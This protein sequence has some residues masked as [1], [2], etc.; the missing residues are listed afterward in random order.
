MAGYVL[1]IVIEDT[2]PPVWRRV[3]IPEMV[4]FAELH[5]VI[6]I[7]FGWSGSHLHIF[8]I[9]SEYTCIADGDV[10]G[11]FD[12]YIEKETLVEQFFPKNK[13]IRY[14]YDFGDEWRHKIIYEK[15][16]ENY[17][18]RYTTLLK[19]RGDNFPED[20]GGVWGAEADG[21]TRS[22]FDQEEVSG[23]LRTL[24]CPFHEE[25]AV[26]LTEEITQEYIEKM[27][28]DFVRWLHSN[29]RT[30]S[31]ESDRKEAPSRLS[32]RINLWKEFLENESQMQKSEADS[33]NGYR[34]MTLPFIREEDLQT[35]GATLEI[36]RGEKTM[37]EL[38]C[39][40]GMKEARD[41]CKYLQISI[42]DSWPVSRMAEM[43]AQTFREHP[44]YILYI[45]YE[46]QYKEFLR[47][48]KFPC[49]IVRERPQDGDVLIKAISIGLA[50]LKVQKRKNGSRASLSFAKDLSDILKSLNAD[51]KKQT[52]RKLKK[53]AKKLE[54]LI[55]VYGLID[56][57]SLYEMFRQ[58]Y[59]ETMSREELYRG[60]Y[61]YA[62]MNELVNTGYY[63]DGG[64]Y[65]SALQIDMEYILKKKDEYAEGLNYV[66][67]PAAEIEK[68]A[69]DI[70][71]RSDWID[72]LFT[73]LHF[74]LGFTEDMAAVLLEEIFSSVVNG[75]SITE[76][77]GIVYPLL[78]KNTNLAERCE[79]WEAVVSLM[80]EVE[81]PMLKGRSR[82]MY[83]EEMGE[84]PWKTG[85]LKETGKW[86]NSKEWRMCQFP[87]EIQESVYRACSFVD[88]QAMH[89]LFRYQE[90]EKI[91]SE[92]FL[93]LLAKAHITGCEFEKAEKLL[94]QL[95]DSSVL[96]QRA[97]RTL[98]DRLDNG[99]DVMDEEDFQ[100]WH[101]EEM[102]AKSGKQTY[103]RETPKIG[104]NTQ[105][106]KK[107]PMSLRFR[108]KI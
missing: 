91:R 86:R 73:T 7:I 88:R 69:N 15:V 10:C 52:Y 9:P 70:G 97:A 27:T 59:H 13:W 40:L 55:L 6:Q 54:C 1:K 33:E 53:F 66:M 99:W 85:M 107:Y 68:R 23:K 32:K 39:D 92:E 49:G 89:Q 58:T 61:W 103:V 8:S 26:E 36:V 5:E 98:K 93:Y 3:I 24:I 96:G 25:L 60:V 104:R 11:N 64:N 83:A 30:R 46:Q 19:F 62:R 38:L 105:N 84:S 42:E 50:D 100:P 31:F 16:D 47:W 82:N 2:H 79:L 95:E 87:A 102:D 71:E 76:I 57:D 90:K 78:P 75:K 77:L 101:M 29:F 45:L 37:A 28:D 41:Y 35:T 63:I 81:L 51:K 17:D 34:Q 14:V 65:V 21:W 56:F 94:R 18:K 48:T 43:I 80:L 12:D 106:R 72:I 20:C 74:Q 67:F 108:E 44:E 22:V 4:T